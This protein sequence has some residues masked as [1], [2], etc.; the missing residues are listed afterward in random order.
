MTVLPA[1]AQGKPPAIVLLS[2]GLSPVPADPE[3]PLASLTISGPLPEA[4]PTITSRCP[5]WTEATLS[6]QPSFICHRGKLVPLG[7]GQG[8][9]EA[10]VCPAWD[11]HE[12]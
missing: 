9:Q 4:P 8:H 3:A 6:T 7:Q 1:T 2:L 10:A 12:S 11:I 5:Q